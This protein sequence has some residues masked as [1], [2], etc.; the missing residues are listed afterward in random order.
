MF[1]ALVAALVAG[2]IWRSRHLRA[3]E[4]ITY[5]HR[6]LGDDGVVIGGGSFVLERP[7]APAV[8]LLHGAGDTTQSLRYLTSRS[9]CFPAMAERCRTSTGSRRMR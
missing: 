5:Q 6:R 3:L 9:H 1:F 2:A 4:A 7:G 8:L